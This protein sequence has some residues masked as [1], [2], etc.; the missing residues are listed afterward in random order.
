MTISTAQLLGSKSTTF[1]PHSNFSPIAMR[2]TY[3]FLTL[4]LVCTASLSA[5]D[6]PTEIPKGSELRKELFDSIRPAVEAEAKK[7]V[8][9]QGSLKQLGDYAFFDGK[10]VDHGGKVVFFDEFQSSDCVA[11]W[12]KVKGKWRVL[13]VAPG[14]TDAFFLEIYP[15]KFGAPKKLVSSQ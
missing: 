15:D 6:V 1:R 3:L 2:A 10:V 14:I 8:K 13:D 12:K 11:L 9:F 4:L 5:G 7:P